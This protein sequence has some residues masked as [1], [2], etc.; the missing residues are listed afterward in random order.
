M[1][2]D[3]ISL[4]Y[5]QEKNPRSYKLAFFDPATRVKVGIVLPK[6]D[7]LKPKLESAVRWYISS[8]KYQQDALRW[9]LPHTALLPTQ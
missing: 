4:N 1:I 3:I 7:P 6:G 5:V 2:L 8:G 9:R